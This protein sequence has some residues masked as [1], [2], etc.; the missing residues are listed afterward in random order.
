MIES[1][2]RRRVLTI[3]MTIPPIA[4]EL[5]L[6]ESMADAVGRDVSPDELV[7]LGVM[8]MVRNLQNCLDGRCTLQPMRRLLYGLH[9]VG[10]IPPRSPISEHNRSARCLFWKY[11]RMMLQRAEDRIC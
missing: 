6:E 1:P 9:K 3:P 8:A 11:E 2:T 7:A 5:S 4:P 10:G